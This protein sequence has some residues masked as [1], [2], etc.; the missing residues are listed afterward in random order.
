MR[1]HNCVRVD[2]AAK[3]LPIVY[4][5]RPCW[6]CDMN[7]RARNSGRMFWLPELYAW[8][9]DAEPF[10]DALE[11]ELYEMFMEDMDYGTLTGDTGTFDE[12]IGDRP[13]RIEEL[14][15]DIETACVE[16][17]A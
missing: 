14:I 1:D 17:V 6:V 12:W 10:S 9:E 2:M 3:P 13:D 16:V 5:D 4:A 15:A 11:F 8:L 7:R